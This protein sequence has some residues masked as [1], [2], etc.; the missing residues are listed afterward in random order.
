M[1]VSILIKNKNTYYNQITDTV[2]VV[3]YPVCLIINLHTVFDG[4]DNIENII[5]CIILIP[6]SLPSFIL[7][8]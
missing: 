5:E 7:D 4:I 3:I 6:E 1:T 2:T 8:A